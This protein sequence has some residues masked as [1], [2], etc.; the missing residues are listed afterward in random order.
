MRVQIDC[1]ESRTVQSAA[2]Q[3]DI[4]RIVARA[5]KTGEWPVS[6]R[7]PEYLDVSE[8]GDYRESLEKIRYGERLFAGLPSFIRGR[9]NNDLGEL[10]SF[11]S[12][13]RNS[14][15]AVKL[16][17]APAPSVPATP[18]PEPVQAPK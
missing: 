1:S 10:V 3:C 11:L 15:E 14:E 16:G 12:D 18:A 6:N 9:F 17:L 13:P 5:K 8:V 2:A 4:N 7:R